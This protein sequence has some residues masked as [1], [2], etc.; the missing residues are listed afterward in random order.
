MLKLALCKYPTRTSHRLDVGCELQGVA[1][2]SAAAAAARH[3][4]LAGFLQ[5]LAPQPIAATFNLPAGAMK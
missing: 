5:H 1:V 3:R 2:A 4:R